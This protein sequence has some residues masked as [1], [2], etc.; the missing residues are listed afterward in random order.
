[1]RRCCRLQHVLGFS[2]VAC[3]C[4]FTIFVLSRR[5]GLEKKWPRRIDILRDLAEE[6]DIVH[7][8]QTE[9]SEQK[10]NASLYEPYLFVAIK[11]GPA[12][13]ERRNRLREMWVQSCLNGEAS[14][15]ARKKKSFVSCAFVVGKANAETLRKDVIAEQKEHNDM[16]LAP[17]PEGYSRMTAKSLWIFLWFHSNHQHHFLMI[18]EDDALVMFNT[19]LPWIGVQPRARF[20]AGH[21]H[22][23]PIVYRCPDAANTNP[24]C[25]SREAYSKDL[26]P[27]FASSFAYVVSRDITLLAAHTALGRIAFP[28]LPGNAEAAMVGV[29]LDENGI[30]LVDAKAFINYRLE[31]CPEIAGTGDIMVV[32]NAPQDIMEKLAENIDH[33]KPVCAGVRVH[34]WQ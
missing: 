9:R 21:Y 27:R 6:E 30:D 34:K 19:L 11:S 28:G 31:M 8:K 1:M 5:R 26:Y 20:Y 18:T 22:A 2:V 13:V 4:A 10:L 17:M 14:H 16:I 15:A 33:K 32:G 25:V 23:A 7:L 12:R 29:L 3:F 24:D